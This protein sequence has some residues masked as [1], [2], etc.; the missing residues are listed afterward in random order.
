MKHAS[1]LTDDSG[2]AIICSHAASGHPIL[3]AIRDLPIEPADSGWQFLCGSSKHEDESAVQVWSVREVI[4]T[5][6]SL[7]YLV[8]LPPGTSLSRTNRHKPWEVLRPRTQ[9]H[10]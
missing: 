3:L 1:E 8:D 7:V 4:E 6:P 10:N 2:A 9:S 5:D